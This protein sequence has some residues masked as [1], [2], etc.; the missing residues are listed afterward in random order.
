MMSANF[1]ALAILGA[2]CVASVAVAG[3]PAAV[4]RF[5]SPGVIDLSAYKL[6]LHGPEVAASALDAAATKEI[7]GAT[8]LDQEH[9][10]L[11]FSDYLFGC[12]AES[13]TCVAQHEQQVIAVAGAA[14]RRDKKRL[15]IKP[16]AAAAVVFVDWKEPETKTADGD[17]EIHW[18]LGALPK[19]GFHQVEV[20]FEHDAPGSFLV[21]PKTGKTAFVHTGSDIVA[22]SP[23]G[24]RLVTFNP[25]GSELRLR[26]VA[27]DADGPRA[28][29]ECA[30]GESGKRPAVAFKGWKNA[31]T[32]DV[33]I[34]ADAKGA[35]SALRFT[36][37]S[38]WHL[39]TSDVARLHTIGFVCRQ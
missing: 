20:Q 12:A 35:A 16:S 19:N 25:D 9:A 39:A 22:Q 36:H 18:Y 32:F 13:K 10:T 4:V 34:E 6:Q 5:D 31:A 24:M 2:S 1:K 17:G 27:L 8:A 23:D 29:L 3:E 26:I 33:V 21:N 14:V 7:L 37:D 28:E 15:S 38:T 11:P 30:A